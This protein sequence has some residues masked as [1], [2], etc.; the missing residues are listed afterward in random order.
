MQTDEANIVQP[1]NE[2]IEP[3]AIVTARF[4]A[5]SGIKSCGLVAKPDDSIDKVTLI[6]IRYLAWIGEALSTHLALGHGLLPSPKPHAVFAAYFDHIEHL[7]QDALDGISDASRMAGFLMDK[8]TIMK[9]TLDENGGALHRGLTVPTIADLQALHTAC[10][11]FG[12][13]NDM[14][15]S[16]F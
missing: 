7:V 10:Q 8:V 2:T 11:N 6:T 15:A 1:E 5:T 9:M 4:S 16:A 12:G 13:R 14:Q 3:R